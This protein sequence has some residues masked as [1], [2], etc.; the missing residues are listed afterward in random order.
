MPKKNIIKLLVVVV[1]VIA[2][3]SLSKYLNPTKGTI[4]AWNEA[5][6]ECLPNG[7]ANLAQHI[8]QAIEVRVN[9]VPEIIPAN[10]GS[11]NGCLAEVHTHDGEPGV[12]HVETTESDKVLHL[13]DFFTVW[14]KPFE[15]EGFTSM[16]IV[17]GATST[18]K[19]EL[20][21][22]NKQIIKVIYVESQE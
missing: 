6:V 22:A 19:S 7:H 13:K 2:L 5:G 1:V 18:E 17:D 9:D 15:R 12:I 11:V 16:V 4:A 10:I 21:L 14:G 3:F 20:G 8:H